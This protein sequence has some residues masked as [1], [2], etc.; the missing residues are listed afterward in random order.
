[1]RFYRVV[2]VQLNGWTLL[3]C[4]SGGQAMI[5]VPI[6]GTDVL[7]CGDCLY[8]AVWNAASIAANVAVE[9]TWGDFVAIPG[10]YLE[11]SGEIPIVAMAWMLKRVIVVLSADGTRSFWFG[12]P[13]IS[14]F[15][16]TRSVSLGAGCSV[17]IELAL[18]R[19]VDLTTW[20]ADLP[21]GTVFNSL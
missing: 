2:D 16:D 1:M 11:C 20:Y 18:R 8:H 15:N 7:A 21:P 12:T 17:N 3:S 19:D 4:G 5:P 9:V 6:Y 13:K 14:E 10:Q